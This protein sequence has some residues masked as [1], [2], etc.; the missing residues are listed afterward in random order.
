VKISKF[1]ETTVLC[2]LAAMSNAT[3]AFA[4]DA[5]ID[6]G[7]DASA[8]QVDDA[9]AGDVILVTGSRI[10]R[11]NLES[12]V[13]ISTVGGEE[14]FQTGQ[15][16]IGDTLNEL[17]QLRATRQQNN[18][19]LGVG[20]A[21]LNNLDLRGLGLQRTLVLV[22]G[23]RHVASD[24]LNTAAAVDINTI[25]ADLVDR[26]DIVTGANSAIY[27][28]DAIAGV[29]NFILKRNFEGLQLRANV[30]VSEEGFG[31]NQYLSAM[32][33]MNFG[34]GR[35]NVT[36]HAE[37]ARQ[38]R[39]FGS[40]VPH[41]LSNNGLFI[42]DLDGAGLVNGSDGIPDRTFIRDVRSTTLHFQGLVPI[43]QPAGAGALCGTGIPS[44]NGATLPY[45]CTFI[46]QSSGALA[47]QTG[48]RFGAGITG[49][50]AGG[51]GQTGREG[52]SVTMFPGQERYNANL[53]AHY[54][55]SEAL[56]PFI[57]AKFARVLS[58]G[59]N[60]GPTSIQGTFVQ[61]DFRERFRLDNP[62]LD[63]AARATLASAIQASGFNTDFQSRNPL[64]AAD[65]AAIANGTYRFVVGRSL[66][67]DLGPRDENFTRD[68][69][70]VVAGVR[71]QFNDDWKYE[72]SA[73]YGRMDEKTRTSGYVDRQRFM[74][75]IDAGRNPGTGQI[76]CRAQ[77][78]SAARVPYSNPTFTTAQ[79]A[80]IAAR[81]AADIAACIPYNPFGAADNK[82]AGKYF[83]YD[84]THKAKIDQLVVSG[85]MSGD[86]SQLFELP[87]G[88][89]KFALGAEYRRE[90][91]AYDNDDF[92][93]TGGTNLV[94]IGDIDADPFAVKEAFAE[95]QIPIL[96]GTPFFH[97]L[98]ISG[99]ARIADY[100]G[101]T[102]TVIAYNAGLLWAPIPELRLRANYGRSVRA[103]NVS[104]TGFPIVANFAP[105]FQDPCRAANIGSGT[106]F[107]AANCA[108]DL[109]ALLNTPAFA[110]IAAFSLPVLSGSNPNLEEESSN[111]LTVGAVVQPLAG[112]SLSVDYFDIKVDNVITSV[113]A[114]NIANG[115]YDLP[116]LDNPFCG[117]F[118]RY[119]GAA[120]SPIGE[121]PGQIA[122]NSLLQA[123]LNFAKRVRRGLD[124]EATFRTNLGADLA[125]NTRLLFTHNLQNSNFENPTL[126]KFEN[127]LLGEL[128]NPVNEARW[129]VALKH[130]PF[131][132]AYQM[133]YIDSM[134]VNAF[135]DFNDLQ[136]RP[137][138]DA[139]YA[140][141]RK[142]PAVFYHDIRFEWELDTDSKARDLQFT[143]GVDNLFDKAPPLGAQGNGERGASGSIAGGT[144]MYNTRG[145]NFFAG[146]RAH[147]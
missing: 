26:V 80:S 106:Q 94:L 85:F 86:S 67:N 62:F 87:G 124:F 14:L 27:G 78:D 108:A 44:G 51:N 12:T 136:G 19:N 6:S 72:L 100:N 128:G 35:G 91:V 82:A 15:T 127:A 32:Y 123:P 101:A 64:T 112:L 99:A 49:G 84:A 145:R 113:S 59:G 73:N 22:N 45:N 144:S 56:E 98:T 122:A 43:V 97:D 36:L 25:P 120:T 65:R 4:Q 77:F 40:Q 139:D 131:T 114:Q 79:N 5:V 24:I 52:R 96:A 95:V 30:G 68:T 42:T 115:C 92:V 111:S 47:A 140:D 71:G 31:S 10:A 20:I 74:L 61:F 142:F 54:T 102:G 50:I 137:P 38:Q 55:I 63:P 125:L 23:R 29:V 8:V 133:S 135:E 48:A 58:H 34:G 70:R 1:L 90:N 117:L 143:F 11:P 2:S 16:N 89:V 13:P 33:G 21:G 107:R 119:R 60:A 69:Y 93:E 39:I 105:G 83:S 104:E 18:S 46:F 134:W 118:A 53:V 103:P 121:I 9:T 41:I 88:P 146:L 17:P 141:V 109:G 28:S 7:P 147:F 132:I 37:Y 81:L 116:T 129:D 75:S 110:N 130:G 3:S 138:Q 66:L 76:Q 57:E 126:P